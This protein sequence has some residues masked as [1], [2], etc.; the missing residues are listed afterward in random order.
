M[1]QKSSIFAFVLALVAPVAWGL[2]F[3]KHS[4]ENGM[5][6]YIIPDHRSP[7]AV[8]F[9]WYKAGAGDEING[10]TGVAHMLEHL[11]FKGTQNI[12]PQEFS[13]I[14]ARHGGRDNAFTSYDYTAYFQKVGKENLPKMMEIEA[15]RM[16]GLT[17]TDKEFQPERDVI[18]EER[19]WRVETKPENRFY[20]E[21]SY[22]ALPNHPYGRPVIGWKK[23]IENYTYQMSHDWYKRW[24]QPNNAVLILIGD[25]TKEEGLKLVDETYAKV[26]STVEIKHDAWPVEPRWREPKE[27]KKVDEEVQVPIWVRSYRAPS[28]FAGVAGVDENLNDALPLTLLSKIFGGGQTSVLYEKLVKEK[29]LADAVSASYNGVARGE[30]SFDVVI[31]PKKD[32]KLSEVE[33]AYEEVLQ[34]FLENAFEQDALNRARTSLVS[35]DVYARDDP[36]VA[37][38]R[39]GRWLMA[40]GTAETFDAWLDEIKTI[41]R[42][43]VMDMAKRYLTT[44]DYTTGYLVGDETQF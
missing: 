44:N 8:N 30:S 28:Y 17:F 31:R 25:I 11:M 16:Q 39:L 29:K 38:Y 27:F 20:E 23:D 42:N 22:A 18:L 21:F 32:V 34:T 4:L 36:F 35:S 24:Y 43:D 33:K 2:D 40:G 3:S 1:F 5:D 41:S 37:A 19:R 6:V 9:V 26:P 10:Q 13:K 12:P 7:V 15:D 14:V